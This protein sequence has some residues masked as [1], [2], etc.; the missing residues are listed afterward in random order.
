MSNVAIG[1]IG[2]VILMLLMC[3]RVPICYCLM[4]VGLVGMWYLRGFSAAVGGSIATLYSR[5][6][7]YGFSAIPMFVLLGFLAFHSG[8]LKD[9]FGTANKWFGHI[10]GGLPIA[11]I[12]GGAGFGAVCG[13]GAASGASLSRRSS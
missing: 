13:S 10:R 1:I 11:G 12:I 7:A 5:F 2:I 6:T 3:L 8:M 4:S 9:L